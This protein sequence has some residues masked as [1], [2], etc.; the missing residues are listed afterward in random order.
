LVVENGHSEWSLR[1]EESKTLLWNAHS[2]L[3]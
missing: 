2:I 3:A 1:N